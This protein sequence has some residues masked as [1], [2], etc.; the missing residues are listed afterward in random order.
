M[1]QLIVQSVLSKPSHIIS[2][3]LIYVQFCVVL[4]ES[5]QE[6]TVSCMTSLAMIANNQIKHQATHHMGSQPGDLQ[7]VTL[8]CSGVCIGMYR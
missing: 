8:S 6:H 7:M 3:N 5:Q 1:G 2:Y 4:F